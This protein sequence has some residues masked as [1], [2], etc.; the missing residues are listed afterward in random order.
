MKIFSCSCDV[1]PRQRRSDVDDKGFHFDGD[2]E[3]IQLK[4]RKR[5]KREN[6]K[7]NGNEQLQEISQGKPRGL[8]LEALAMEAYCLSHG[9]LG[10][11][12]SPST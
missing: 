10:A 11:S 6:G 12:L 2:M 5:K 1:Q 8:R 7:K 4:S 3:W 9:R